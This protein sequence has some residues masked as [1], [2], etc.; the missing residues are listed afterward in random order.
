MGKPVENKIADSIDDAYYASVGRRYV[1]EQRR[2]EENQAR[3]KAEASARDQLKGAIREALRE[4]QKEQRARAKK[5][6]GE[7]LNTGLEA[8]IVTGGFAFLSYLVV[9]D[10]MSD[11]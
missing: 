8:A 3:K 9:E 5:V 1:E 10:I 11:D 6:F 2:E 7:A 4:D